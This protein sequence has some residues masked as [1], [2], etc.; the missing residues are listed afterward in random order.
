MAEMGRP[1]KYNGD[2]VN[3]IMHLA[4]EG[5]TDKQIASATGISERT[6]NLWKHRYPNF[7]QSLKENKA[8]I[9]DLV[10]ASL[11]NRAMGYTHKDCKPV[12]YEGKVTDVFEYDKHIPPDVTSCIFWLKNRRPD[13]WREKQEFEHSGTPVTITYTKDAG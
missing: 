5:K 11:L 6:L 13:E 2:L 4:K 7:L 9:D 12:M 1:T 10:E 8:S 3:F